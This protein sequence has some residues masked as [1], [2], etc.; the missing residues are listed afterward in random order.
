MSTPI[1]KVWDAEQSKYVGIPAIKG[2]DGKSAYQYAVDGGYT[3]T[4][5][6]FTAKLAAGGNPTDEQVAAAVETWLEAHPE[7]TTTVQD[8]SITEE[9]LSES[10]AGKIED[11][12]YV[13]DEDGAKY[14]IEVVGGEIVLTRAYEKFPGKEIVGSIIVHHINPVTDEMYGTNSPMLYDP[15]NLITVSRETHDYIHYGTIP[16]E[17][18]GPR[19][20]GDT[21]LW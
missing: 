19:S 15:D 6:E 5:E 11:A 9:K 8:G 13:Y 14:S 17:P 20:P 2:I 7:A 16:Q 21:K 3:G 12:G 1:C 4:E 18:L 10:L